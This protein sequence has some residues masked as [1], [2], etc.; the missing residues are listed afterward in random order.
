MVPV[1]TNVVLWVHCTHIEAKEELK[2][3]H[4]TIREG[5]AFKSVYVTEEEKEEIKGILVRPDP[6]FL[7]AFFQYSTQCR[8]SVNSLGICGLNQRSAGNS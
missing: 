3:P 6:D 2:K 5:D 1:T 8:K 7:V 4:I